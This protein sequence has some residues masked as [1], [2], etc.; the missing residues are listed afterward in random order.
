MCG[1]HFISAKEHRF[2]LWSGSKDWICM[3]RPLFKSELS[4]RFQKSSGDQPGVSFYRYFYIISS[5]LALAGHSALKK[6]C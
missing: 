2:A 3:Y 5:I 4:L 1:L 6:Y